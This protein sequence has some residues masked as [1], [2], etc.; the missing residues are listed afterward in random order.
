MLPFFVALIMDTVEEQ[1]ACIKFRVKNG[2]TGAE[3]LQMLRTAFSDDCL[4]QTVVYQWVKRFREGRESLKDD[5]RPG[6]PSTACNEQKVDQ[7]REKIR[8]DRRLTIREIA[9]KVN[10]SFGSCQAIITEDLAMRSVA[11]KFVPRLFSDDQKS[12][13]LEVCEELKQR[14][15]IEPHFMSRIITGD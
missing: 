13:R 1:R 14:V 10:I 3:T 4:S 11:A 7:V 9:E 2:K 5:P 12:R 15:E 8:A 6:R